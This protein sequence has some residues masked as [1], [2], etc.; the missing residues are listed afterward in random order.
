V[1]ERTIELE[2]STLM[3]E[4]LLSVIMHDLRSPM[5]SQSLLIDHLHEHYQKLTGPKLDELFYLLKDSSNRIV[6]FSNDF[7]L[8]YDSQRQEFT[9]K[10]E[11]IQL[12]DFLN[13]TTVLYKNIAQ[14]KGLYFDCDIPSGLVL[15]SDRNMLAI[16]IR[17]LV[18]NA[19]KYTTTGGI[20]IS[21]GQENGRILV[22]VKDTGRGMTASRI[23][24][25]TAFGEKPVYGTNPGFGYRFIM[26]L[27]RKLNGEIEIR[28]EPTKGTIVQV[29]F[30]V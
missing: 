13:E 28:S 16:V 21:A 7:L 30:K 23:A 15:A 10:K 27:A 26:E 14:R 11:N 25:I 1:D 8:W 18:D 29:G 9:I 5:Y 24:E 17:N 20:G 19:I 6:Q 4:R 22:R 12:G 2:Q 3:K